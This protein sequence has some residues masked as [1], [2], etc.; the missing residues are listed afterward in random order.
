[1][2]EPDQQPG[3]VRKPSLHILTLFVGFICSLAFSFANIQSV[4][5]A[6]VTQEL[7][8]DV[9]TPQSVETYSREGELRLAPTGSW[10]AQSWRTPDKTISLGGTFA[11][12]G[13]DIYVFRGVADVTFWRYKTATNTWETLA[14]A[15]RGT[16]AGADLQYANGYI[17]AFF[18]GYQKGFGRYSIEHNSWEMLEDF[19]SLI[20]QG[21]SLTTDGTYLYGT[22]GNA[23]QEFYRYNVETDTWSPLAPTPATLSIGS[24]LTYAAG[25]IYATRGTN[26]VTFYRYDIGA[27]TWATMADLPV[28]FNGNVDITTNGTHIFASRQQGTV[29]FYQYTIGSN[30]WTQLSDAPFA[31]T[32]GGVQYVAADGMVYFFAGNNTFRFW[33]YN[34]NTNQFLG[35]AE[36]PNTLAAGSDMVYYNG[37]LYTPRGANT[38]TLYSYTPNTN[39]WA[40][41]Q[42][43]PGNF[44]FDT[45][46]AAAG[47]FLYFFQGNS[48][49]FWRY[50]PGTNTWTTLTAAP[51]AV[52]NGGSLAYPGSGSFLYATRGN[53]L[54]D[55]WRYNIDTPGWTTMAPLPTGVVANIGSRLVSDGTDIFFI[56]GAGLK[57][58]Y[59]YDVDDNTW[60]QLADLPFAPYY[61][62]DIVY[63]DG[64]LIALAGAYK[65]ELYEYDIGL[66][67]WRQL[68]SF[69]PYGPTEIG[70]WAGASLERDSLNDVFYMTMGGTRVEMFTYT[71]GTDE[72]EATGTWQSMSLDFAYVESWEELVAVDQTPGDSSITYQTRSSSN[73][74]DWSSWETATGGV[75]ASPPARYLQVKIL[76]YAA[77]GQAATP[78]VQSLAVVANGDGTPPTNPNTVTGLS[79]AVGGESLTNGNPYKFTHPYFSWTGAADG[80]TAVAGYYVYFGTNELV[81]P[82]DPG[83]PSSFQTTATYQANLQLSTGTYY[84][85]LATK[86]IAGNV[87]SPV[88]AFVY[89]YIGVS[90][91]SSVISTTTGDFAGTPTDVQVANNEIKLS[92]RPGGFWLEE[93][94]TLPPAGLQW[95]G[96][97]SVYDATT[98][99]IYV[100]AA[101]NNAVFRVYDIAT[102]TWGVLAD[103]PAAVNFGGG[104]AAG[105]PGYLY[106][107][108]G[109][110]T[111]TTFWR[112]DINANTWD[113]TVT[114]APLTIGYGSSMAFDG[115]QFIYITRGNNTNTFWRYDTFADEWATLA[116]ANFGAPEN[117]FSNFINRGGDLVID[118]T[119]GMVYA[120]QGN[121]LKGFS[122]YNTNTGSWTVLP[123]VPTLPYDGASLEYDSDA[124]AIYYT[125]GAATPYL[126]KYDIEEAEW[127]QLSSAPVTW[128]SGAGINKVGNALY[129]IRGGNTTG[130]YKYDI[131]KDSWL[132]PTRG[133]FGRVYE[134][135]NLLTIQS[136]ADLL[137][138]D[139]NNFY[140]TRGT[141]SDDFVRWNQLTGEV[142]RL[143]R[144][145]VGVFIGSSMVYRPDTN[146]I[147]L[148]PGS[149]NGAITS[150][151]DRNF[152][153]YSIATDTWS[154]LATDPPPV[155]PTGPGSSMV[156]DGTRYI[157]LSR[158][159][160]NSYY[161]YDTQ[162]AAGS[163]WSTLTNATAALGT[164]AELLFAGD[165]I[166]TLRGANGNPFYRYN[167]GANT[168]TNLTAATLP[169]NMNTDGWLA[170]GG[171]G[172]YYAARGANVADFY[173]YSVAGE[174]WE[175]LANA[176]AQ[177]NTGASGEGNGVNKIFATA[178]LGTNS[179]QD[180]VYTYVVETDD[181]S[182]LTEGE[183]ISQAYDLGS[184]YKWANLTL[185][186]DL[187][188]NTSLQFATRSSEDGSDW[189]E[190]ADVSQKKH[191]GES[192]VFKINSPVNRYLQLRISFASADGVASSVLEDYTI[193]YYSDTTPPTN[194]QTA[195]LAA[196][197]QSSSGT[198]LVS[199]TWYGHASP[200]FTWAE[201]EATNGASDTAVGSGVTG[202]YVYF[203]TNPVANPAEDGVFQTQ[204]E[205]TASGLVSGTTN[206]LR[207]KATDAAGNVAT[208]AWD[209]FVY[210]FDSSEPAAPST[211]VA[212]PV[213]YTATN[214]FDF[215]WTAASASGS[216]VVAWCYKTNASS[217][218]FSVEQCTD[219]ADQLSVAGVEAYK[220]G[221]NVFQVRAKNQANTFSQP[222][223]V[224]YYYADPAN[225]PAPPTNLRLTTPTTNTLNSFGF[226]WDVPSAFLGSAINLSYR[227][228]INAL[229]T[230][231]STTATSLKQLNPGAYATLPGENVFY[232]VAQ[233]EAGN[234][235]YSNYAQV[236]F[237][238]NTIAPGISTDVEIA[239]V[240]VKSTAAWR[241]ALSWDAPIASGS[242]VH[243]YA[244][245]RSTDA[246]NY[247][248]IATTTSN[249]YVNT[250][251]TQIMYYYKIKACDNT[252][253][254]GEFSSVV[255]F[256]PDGRFV[257]APSLT[258]DPTVSDITTR[259]A[260]VA[261]STNRM[262]DSKVAYGT[263]PDKYFE[264][265]VG[266]SEPVTDHQ[267]TLNNLTPGTTYYYTVK[268]TDEDGN[269]GKS[270][271][272][273]FT[274]QPPP[275]TEEPIARNVG[276]TSAVI[277][278]VTRNASR[279]KLYYGES[280]AFG[281]I[282]EI[283]TSTSEST[284]TVE[285]SELK[286]ATKYYYK[287]NTL[288]VDGTE[289]EGE[290]HSFE[291][292]PRPAISSVTVQQINGTA[293]TTLLVRWATNTAVSSIVTYYPTGA[294]Q[295]AKDE[296]NVALESGAHQM[297]LFNLE[298]QTPYSILIRGQDVAGNEA[299]SGV[300][301]ITTSADT[302]PP[303]ITDLKVESEIIGT[304]E[305]AAAQLI[306]SYKTDEP[307]T[308]QVEYGEGT[309][310]VYSQ[311]S[312]QS[313]TPTDNH[314]LIVSGLTPGKVYHLRA[315][316]VDAAGN[317]AFS[318]DKVVVTPKATENALDLV[319]NN[320][321]GIFSFLR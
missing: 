277:E 304:G 45:S 1:M 98:H 210:K 239:D 144:L 196:F 229:P 26:T 99:K 21:A 74:T 189:S 194:P 217:G 274:T 101:V 44:N 251:L 105:P 289:Y 197:S 305:E 51:A 31:S 120:T 4:R 152:Y 94:L 167:I 77:T 252:S 36:A 60:H 297:I 24:D 92:S 246:E 69:A 159:G 16:Y 242:G 149:T 130:F 205:F 221:T 146:Q 123:D 170:D 68:Q 23:T 136:G 188:A 148:I 198:P 88:T 213:G 317:E 34:P 320:L 245:Y 42:N 87:S 204:A 233:D 90:P 82:A 41:L 116:S 151:A 168:W 278:F 306:V 175:Q 61:G 280:S 241:L 121:Y 3:A 261:W 97:N 234:I 83:A 268:W 270:D 200:H 236:S 165:S 76:L 180:G 302:R 147:Y 125:A 279:V 47:T 193:H 46:G 282:K 161:R 59:R 273:S 310:T 166:F 150:P 141:Y 33:K 56:G 291:T 37:V 285:L 49:A 209:A 84:L 72:Y 235:N 179:Y 127:T 301:Q 240:S 18:G 28:V 214:S 154:R 216:P 264:E 126:Y 85:R 63:R 8:W 65:T 122:V 263:E 316:S 266:S 244:V 70:N 78:V 163:R 109:N 32:N 86:D 95:G 14:N 191:V 228:S 250:G 260:V 40:T 134:G 89:D 7:D 311:K 284:Q 308:S 309:G 6:T 293:K 96:V 202:Y 39:A 107:T 112:Y 237:F 135:A 184:V 265:E 281:G 140:L 243:N 249:S 199:E 226:A 113:E 93:R 195:G 262:S 203:G 299:V 321:V 253:N 117:N 258:A 132:L 300:Q 272:G 114:N 186:Y 269:T 314:L 80:Q 155:G 38:A 48:T 67:H 192:T 185:N 119:N 171:D 296:V 219:D 271:E 102:D 129:A 254:C 106:A 183:Y 259:K 143:A 224:N 139:G 25:Y 215:T 307:A 283:V 312:Q 181:S 115:T 142:A 222:K 212:D 104:L 187:A 173:R 162:A 124:H 218:P 256:L 79:Q 64:K 11:S 238:A 110:G 206:Y 50:A 220:V 257:D 29:S 172:Y 247:T 156:Y 73:G 15:P 160:S 55:F 231:Q 66:N 287:I 178:G 91:S 58:L 20:W 71:P 313:A 2:D 190:W 230:P 276:L 81:N 286:D 103:A 52:V 158:G 53:N 288:D 292:L 318:V 27:G 315:I 75:I 298:P 211:V 145:P 319:V 267:L 118:Q 30:S 295:L 164:G 133:L 19:P 111:A 108:V 17:Y 294:P 138:G 227:F 303:Q 13:T 128:L 275:S 176:P 62:T 225:A 208:T 54:T 223:T 35:P 43:A 177:F 22:P 57:V 100:L 12:D 5:A 9:G 157:Y 248:Q 174:A 10:G 290:I 255:N 201:A 137:K 153:V 131:A 207:I 232:I 169:G 182:F